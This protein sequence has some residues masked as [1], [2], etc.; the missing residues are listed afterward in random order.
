MIIGNRAYSVRGVLIERFPRL[1]HWWSRRWLLAGAG[2]AMAGVAACGGGA[3]GGSSSA[4]S[5]KPGASVTGS[6]SASAGSGHYPAHATALSAA[7]T[8]SQGWLQAGIQLTIPGSDIFGAA[9][10]MPAVVNHTNGAVSD[11]DARA[12]EVAFWRAETLNQWAQANSEAYFIAVT[13]LGQQEGGFFVPDA[14]TAL[15]DSGT[16]TDPNCDMFPTAFEVWPHTAAVDSWIGA[17]SYH[18]SAPDVVIVPFNEAN[19]TLTITD[20]G[21]VSL[22]PADP[23]H[24]HGVDR[25]VWVGEV[26]QDGTVGPYF[27]VEASTNCDRAGAVAQMCQS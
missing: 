1:W 19:C 2:F 12:M 20:K 14:Q 21:K 9:P 24:P 17:A 10:P 26:V 25:V 7:P 23:T 13:L 5:A 16:V 3:V 11:A 15:K 22:E 4:A 6:P 18:T 27:K 8:L